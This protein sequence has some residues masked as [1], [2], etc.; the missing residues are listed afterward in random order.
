MPLRQGAEDR[1]PIDITRS[2]AEQIMR[3][4]GVYNLISEE[5]NVKCERCEGLMLEEEIILSADEA[6]R[7]SVSVSHC[8]T[9]GRMEYRAMVDTN[10]IQEEDGAPR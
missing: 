5:V 8:L 7:K 3:S 9:C 2:P 10:A 4:R 1:Q 6:R